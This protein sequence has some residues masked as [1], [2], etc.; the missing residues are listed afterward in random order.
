MICLIDGCNRKISARGWCSMHYARW[1][2]HGD[3]LRTSYTTHDGINK[4]CAK[5][6]KVKLLNEFHARGGKC[7]RTR[8]RRSYC[9]DCSRKNNKD[10]LKK[11][12]IKGRAQGL[13]NC[14]AKATY[15]D[16]KVLIKR[17]GGKCESC[18]DTLNMKKGFINNSLEFDHCH[19]SGELRGVLCRGCNHALGFIKED[20]KKALMLSEY[21][22]RYCKGN[23]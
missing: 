19:S 17:S 15:E 21:I 13:R 8:T 11:N 20:F 23:N 14:G 3:P 9:K 7:G 10:W 12:P 22:K 6:K 16:L 2:R 1:H 4:I 18:G 5:C